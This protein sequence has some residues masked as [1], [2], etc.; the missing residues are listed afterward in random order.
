MSNESLLS[1]FYQSILFAA[2]HTEVLDHGMSSFCLTNDLQT[3]VFEILDS[4]FIPSEIILN[5]IH[6]YFSKKGGETKK[7]KTVVLRCRIIV[8]ENLMLQKCCFQ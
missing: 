2:F 5:A 7:K 4:K 1:S 8:I 3:K 6:I